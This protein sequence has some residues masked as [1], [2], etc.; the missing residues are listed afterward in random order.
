MRRHESEIQRTSAP[1]AN[2]ILLI[3]KNI[4]TSL[5]MVSSYFMFSYIIP[6]LGSSF[7]K[8]LLEIQMKDDIKQTN[9]PVV[10]IKNQVKNFH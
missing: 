8:V 3:T 4:G 10:T 1:T 7:F 9:N 2:I 5:L 6:T